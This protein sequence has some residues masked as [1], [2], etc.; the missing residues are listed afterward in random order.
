MPTSTDGVD[1]RVFETLR[2]VV[3]ESMREIVESFLTETPK[4]LSALSTALK[5]DDPDTLRATAHQLKSSCASLGAVHLSG[6]MQQLELMGSQRRLDEARQ[7]IEA[8]LESFEHV[9]KFFSL[10]RAA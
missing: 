5:N 6:I 9:R 7:Q 10:T 2:S 8:A 1:V 4:G 3:G